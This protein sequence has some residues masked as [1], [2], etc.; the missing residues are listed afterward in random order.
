MVRRGLLPARLTPPGLRGGRDVLIPRPMLLLLPGRFLGVVERGGGDDGE[1]D[2]G[3]L[4]GV[5]RGE[6]HICNNFEYTLN[7]V[8]CRVNNNH[9]VELTRRMTG[10]WTLYDDLEKIPQSAKPTSKISPIS[11]H[12]VKID[13]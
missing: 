6:L 7:G 5:E 10:H 12:Y 9:V 3:V 13:N 8:V 11:L 2:I 4:V 1:F